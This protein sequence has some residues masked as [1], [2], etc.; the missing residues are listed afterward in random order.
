MAQVAWYRE[1]HQ[2]LV[3]AHMFQIMSAWRHTAESIASTQFVSQLPPSFVVDD[4]VVDSGESVIVLN[5][6]VAAVVAEL[7]VVLVATFTVLSGVLVMLVVLAKLLTVAVVL[8]LVALELLTVV[9]LAVVAKLLTVAVVLVP[10]APELL[11]IVA[12]VVVTKLLATVVVLVLLPG[13]PTPI[14]PEAPAMHDE[15]DA[16]VGP[17]NHSSPNCPL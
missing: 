10:V 9:V 4:R 5:K 8:V 13:S 3:T 17:S 16:T 1:I 11:P 6:V 15:N 14:Q 12:L 7:I 2:G